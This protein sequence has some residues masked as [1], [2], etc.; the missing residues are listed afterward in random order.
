MAK[1][2]SHA[3]QVFAKRTG[4][5]SLCFQDISQEIMRSKPPNPQVVPFIFRFVLT[6][7]GDFLTASELH[8]R[9]HGQP[10][11]VLGMDFWDAISSECKAGARYKVRYL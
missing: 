5:T 7:G 11:R 10:Q 4:K 2:I 8:I 9:A 1:K 3:V 6:C